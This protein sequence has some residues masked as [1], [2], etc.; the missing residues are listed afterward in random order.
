MT[1]MKILKVILLIFALLL[2]LSGL[3]LLLS[4]VIDYKPDPVELVFDPESPGTVLAEGTELSLA[5]WNIGYGGLDSSMDFFYDGGKQV[6][7]SRNRVSENV[8]GILA[9]LSMFDDFDF[10]MLQEVDRRSKRSFR[11]NEY[12]LIGDSFPGYYSSF[13]SNYRVWFVPVPI[14]SPMGRV[15]SG[16]QTL[17]SKSPAKV[18]RHSFPGNYAWPLKLYMLDRCFLVNY[19]PLDNGKELL[20]INTHNSAYDDG[21]LRR[22]QMAYLKEFILDEYAAGNYV[23]V[24]GDWNQCPPGFE[25]LFE[26]RRF[27]REDLTFIEDSFPEAS[28]S[29]AVDA[30]V[31]T[32][33]RVKTPYDPVESAVTV[34]DFF[35]TSPNIRII[36]VEGIDLGFRFSD[37]QPVTLR[38][39]LD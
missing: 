8:D 22:G 31:P 33:R 30:S 27:D 19:H 21:S 35:L 29:W 18:E 6:R 14:K 25:P 38:V 16:L 28:W 9:T 12:G 7:P 10:V 26:A 37:H 11:T 2:V 23:I 36:K 32:N 24:G 3:F 20:V 39:V 15:D 17:S 13:G 5:I 34:I 4:T 1:A